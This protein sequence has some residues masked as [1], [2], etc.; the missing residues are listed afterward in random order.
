MCN[1]R[2]RDPLVRNNTLLNE[3]ELQLISEMRYEFSNSDERRNE[4]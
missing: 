1:V 3:F 4:M 2:S